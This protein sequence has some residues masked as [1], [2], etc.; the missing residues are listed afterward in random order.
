MVHLL[1]IIMIVIGYYSP[2]DSVLY[3]LGVMI[4]GLYLCTT[5]FFMAKRLFEKT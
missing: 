5:L 1:V 4:G 3:R 2:Y